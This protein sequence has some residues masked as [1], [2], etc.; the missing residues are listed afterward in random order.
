MFRKILIANRGE[1]V[2][3]IIRACEKLGV[4]PVVIHSKA[5]SG[6]D[7]L[8]SHVEKH[9]LQGPTLASTYLNG[10]Q[11]I[12]IA[13]AC[14]ADAI[15]PGYG[16]LAENSAFAQS[17]IDNSLGW[18]GPSPA[19]MRIMSGKETSRKQAILAGVPVTDAVSGTPGELSHLAGTLQYPLLVKAV[20]GGGGRGMRIINSPGEF[21]VEV[22][23]ASRE[24]HQYFGDPRI[25]AEQ[26]IREAKHIEVQ[27][28]GD[29]H[30]NLVHLFERE[31]S[32]QRRYQKIIEESPSPSLSADQRQAILND[33][34]KLAGSAGYDNAGTLEF[35]LA[36]DGQHYFM[37]M[38]TRI[39]VEHPVSEM[40]TGIDLVDAQ[41]RSAAGY[42]LNI[43]QEEIFATGH[44]I[45]CRICAEDPF[46]GFD[47]RPGE[48]SLFR[49]PQGDGVRT[50]HAIGSGFEVSPLFDSMVAKV[51]AWAPDRAAALG[52]MESALKNMVL[53]GIDTTTAFLRRLLEHPVF[54]GSAFTTGFIAACS[55][56][57]L[58]SVSIHK[59]EPS[60][61]VIAAAG[62]LLAGAWHPGSALNSDKTLSPWT[63]IGYWRI[64]YGQPVEYQNKILPAL[65]GSQKGEPNDGIVCSIHPDRSVWISLD[66]HTW[67]FTNPSL[68]RQPVR[69]EAGAEEF[70]SP[71]TRGPKDDSQVVAP[72]PG[73]LTRLL[74]GEGDRVLEG[75]TLAV[76][77][78]MKTEN[79]VLA[80]CSGRIARLL[81]TAGKPVKLNE[82]ILEM[83]QI[84]K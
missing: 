16:F 63:S 44:A 13:L 81:V 2:N 74:V 30:G 22:E 69:R 78:S 28:L 11:I 35:L 23:T 64:A 79:R 61:E 47:P 58:N 40:V 84:N 70:S 3:R 68:T 71:K 56:E 65:S 12:A 80:G 24:A 50:E 46:S 73:L 49:A 27:V 32:V 43:K 76:I 62:R 7:Y 36:P 60:E 19:V 52:R 59:A 17:C 21:T 41:I 31:C 77:E 9:L 1:I 66:G 51:I 33:A 37:E 39:Q 83:D 25:F 14:G 18:I 48:V 10:E 15:H 34:V 75:D 29:R 67:Q 53:H 4:T 26:F 57:I 20:S 82:L 54:T 6:L 42:P 55:A 8:A 72:L 5:D 45:E 38:N